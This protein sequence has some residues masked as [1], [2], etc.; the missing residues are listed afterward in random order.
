MKQTSTRIDP[1]E[2]VCPVT[3]KRYLTRPEWF[4][5]SNHHS[6]RIGVLDGEIIL[7]QS[8]GR[9]YVEDVVRYCSTIEAILGEFLRP[10]RKMVLLEDYT[11]LT[12]SD[13]ATRQTYIDF[14]LQHQDDLHGIFF[15]GLNP[16]LKL[17]VRLSRRLLPLRFQVEAFNDYRETL[18]AACSRLGLALP[19]EAAES[20]G[21]RKVWRSSTAYATFHPPDKNALVRVTLHGELVRSDVPSLAHA[22]ESFLASLTLGPYRFYLHL[23]LAD[24]SQTGLI[25]LLFAATSFNRLDKLF[26]AR[27]HVVSGLSSLQ[28]L[29]IMALNLSCLRRTSLVP[30]GKTATDFIASLPPTPDS[31]PGP[32]LRGSWWNRLNS[33]IGRDQHETAEKLMQFIGGI[34][35]DSEGI[36]TNPYPPS[37]P[38][39]QVATSLLVVKSDFD[40]LLAE[41]VRRE[42]ELEAAKLRAEEANRLQARFLANVSHEICTPLNAILGM[43]EMLSDT[44]LEPQQQELLRTIRQS[45]QGLLTVI[46]DILDLSRMEAGE[47]HLSQEPFDPTLVFEDVG[48]MLGYLAISK[49]LEWRVHKLGAIPPALRG[50]PIRIRQVLINLAGNAVKFT[51]RGHVAMEMRRV[52]SSGGHVVLQIRIEDTGPGIPSSRIGELF[53]PF[54]QLDGSLSRRHGGTGLGLAIA[55]NLVKQMG[56]SLGV[57]SSPAGSVFSFRLH[58]PEVDPTLLRLESS[59]GIPVELSGRI[60]VA[61]D[62]RVNQKVVLGMLQK[63]GLEADVVENGREA[64]QWLANHPSEHQLVLMDIQMPEMD[65]IEAVQRMRKGEAGDNGRRLPVIALTAHAMEGDREQFLRQGMDDYLSKPMRLQDLR[66]VLERWLGKEHAPEEDA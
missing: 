19:L 57:E 62:N 46:N 2:M 32:F 43:G 60:L 11:H 44:P 54:R 58:L 3:G 65:G 36:A 20:G 61:E 1:T 47:F 29:S 38:F 66:S 33:R 5:S 41:R 45:S 28:R 12:A 6:Y 13:N 48:R 39:H 15:F 30:R 14:H 42:H 64:L 17:F 31:Q 59:T 7:C 9:T 4:L 51:E 26:P 27:H 10:G 50:D 56:G 37:S 35:W 34:Q 8:F 55:H 18:L 53:Q 63:L 22:F 16:F 23:D 24:F 40:H 21:S 25:P 49:G 52:V